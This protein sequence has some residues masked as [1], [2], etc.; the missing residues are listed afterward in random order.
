[1]SQ[2]DTPTPQVPETALTVKQR[3]VLNFIRF[4][5]TQHGYSPSLRQIQEAIDARSVSVAAYHVRC[6]ADLGF[7]RRDPGVAR[8]LVIADPLVV[9]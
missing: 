4:Y 2:P 6:L 1:M 7:L 5:V 9:A 8:G 3:R